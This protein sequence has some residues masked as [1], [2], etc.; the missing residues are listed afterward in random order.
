MN[1]F[2]YALQNEIASLEKEGTAVRC[3]GN[4]ARLP[5]DI[6]ELVE[7]TEK[8][9]SKLNGPTLVLAVSY[10]GREEIVEGV[11]KILSSGISPESVDEKT[12]SS[13]LFTE[14]IPDP[15]IIIRTGGEVRLSNFLPWQSVYSEFFFT[16]TYWPDFS[17][18]E[19]DSMMNAYA[20]RERR[21]GN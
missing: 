18:T 16:K 10:G 1:L 21:I 11:R 12:F 3:I 17:K 5:K 13:A 19:F 6:Q 15:D 7:K 14:G 2:R 8:K 4:R 20:K 9:N